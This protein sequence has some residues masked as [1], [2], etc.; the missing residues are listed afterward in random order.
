MGNAYLLAEDE[1]MYDNKDSQKGWAEHGQ[2]VYHCIQRV[3][4]IC[5]I[6]G[7]AVKNGWG[8]MQLSDTYLSGIEGNNGIHLLEADDHMGDRR[9]PDHEFDTDGVKGHKADQIQWGK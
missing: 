2:A 9:V 1:Q 8:K 6:Y 4:E 3:W 5:I 7:S